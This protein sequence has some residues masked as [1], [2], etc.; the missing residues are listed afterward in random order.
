MLWKSLKEK[1]TR[2][3][4]YSVCERVCVRA[5]VRVYPKPFPNEVFCHKAWFCSTGQGQVAMGG[6]EEQ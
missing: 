6:G 5:C 2:T 1:D 4:L 3:E